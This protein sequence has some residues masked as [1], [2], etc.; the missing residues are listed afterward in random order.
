MRNERSLS[1]VWSFQLDPEGSVTVGSLNPDRQIQVPMPWQAA[2]PELQSY[3]GYGWYSR[4][5]DVEEEWLAGEVLLQ[6]GAV[7]YWCQVFVNGVLAG[8][9]EG[10]YTPVI[11]PIAGLLREGRNEVAVR[12][13]DAAQSAIT[14]PRWRR[15]ENGGPQ[16][17]PPFDPEDIPH[18][19][20]EWYVN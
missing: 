13:F 2:F 1:G 6:F 19:K 5:V 9:H 12:V 4:S 10:G 3:S 15:Y 17:G 16:D 7:D 14:I 18:G 20:Q 11:L 8:E